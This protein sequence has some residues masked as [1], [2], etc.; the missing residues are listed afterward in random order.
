MSDPVSNAEIEDVL[1]S[2]R[3]LVSESATFQAGSAAAAPEGKIGSDENG[4]DKTGL[5]R[6]A[7]APSEVSSA[8]VAHVDKDQITGKLVLT[9]AFRV[10]DGRSEATMAD[11]AGPAEN[12]QPE[13]APEAAQERASEDAPLQ[14][15]E[16][17]SVAQPAPD[18]AAPEDETAQAEEQEAETAG[19][20]EEQ[21]PAAEFDGE[22]TCEPD[23]GAAQAFE[24]TS[25]REHSTPADE[26]SLDHRVAE[27]EAAVNQSAVDFEPDLG[28]AVEDLEPGVFL[29]SRAG[30]GAAQGDASASFEPEMEP[31]PEME[32]PTESEDRDWSAFD[33][34]VA[35]FVD[36]T[37][38][39]ADSAAAPN[40]GQTA[41]DE[42]DLIDEDA[43]RDLVTRL[44]REELHG[45]IGEKITRN[46][47]RLV[48]R[49]VER[50]LTLKSLE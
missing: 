23:E 11:G 27:L 40:A 5:G 38:A 4:S 45:A 9:P 20:D 10:H 47:R 46:I 44:V 29:R 1:S 24:F 7:T 19:V 32:A 22:P 13:N 15:T 3:R 33:A 48:R 50:A 37:E 21:N 41:D 39:R 18:P 16:A 12:H 49:E 26:P 30:G 42:A 28:D 34:E 25:E 14:L 36:G 2:I 17:V 43:L 6:D 35:A 31:E 8:A